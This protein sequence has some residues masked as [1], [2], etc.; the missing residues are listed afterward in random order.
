M[1]SHPRLAAYFRERLTHI[2]RERWSQRFLAWG[3]ATL[4]ALRQEQLPPEQTPPYVLLY[5]GAHMEL[6]NIDA[7]RF[8]PLVSDSW[9]QAWETLEG[10]YARLPQ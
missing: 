6:A 7:T 3:E 9:R 2:E 5:Y 8:S 4:E 10:S 1:F